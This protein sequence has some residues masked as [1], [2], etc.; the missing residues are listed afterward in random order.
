MSIHKNVGRTIFFSMNVLSVINPA[1]EEIAYKIPL[2][3]LEEAM[4]AISKSAAAQK[5]WKRVPIAERVKLCAGVISAFKLEQ[6]K[7]AHE[8]SVQMGKPI[9]QALAEVDGLNHRMQKMMEIAESALA[10]KVLPPLSGFTRKI[11]REPLGVLLNI[12]AWNYPLLTAVNVVVPAIL[13]GNSVLIKHSSKTP[14]SGQHFATA[15]KVAGAPEGLVVSLNLDHAVTAEVIGDPRIQYIGFTGSVAGGHEIYQTTAKNRFIDVGLELGG[16]DPAY[17]RGDA[18]IGYAA[19][20]L[21]SGA[22]YNAGQSCCGVKRIYVHQTIY[23]KFLRAFLDEAKIYGPGDPLK[24]NTTLGPVVDRQARE[25]LERQVAG[26]I[27]EGGEIACGGKSTEVGGR[28]F[29]WEPTVVV[30]APQKS[31]VMQDESFGPLTTVNEVAGDLEAIKK[32]ND[33]HLGLTASLWTKDENDALHLGEQLEVGTVFMN[34][35]DFLDPLLPWSGVKD[36]GKG[37][38]LSHL[39][40]L[41]LTRPKAYHFRTQIK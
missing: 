19:K 7:I 4:E 17:V 5:N 32:M 13:S 28:G 37:A 34:R 18:D 25:H 1:T 11:A 29:F 35:C 33:S 36:T 16:K 20:N 15:F 26:A 39:G 40:L 14:L 38:T 41:Q 9:T 6:L 10:E 3:T 12:P 2:Q 22:F 8:I 30:A 24:K 27:K 21:A 23:K 31:A